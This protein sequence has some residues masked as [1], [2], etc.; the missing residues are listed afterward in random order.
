MSSIGFARPLTS[1]TSGG[2]LERKATFARA[3]AV[4]PTTVRRGS[5]C[6]GGPWS[7]SWRCPPAEVVRAYAA[8]NRPAKA[9]RARGLAGV[10]YSGEN[11]RHLRRPASRPRAPRQA[12]ARAPTAGSYDGRDF[13]LEDTAGIDVPAA[14]RDQAAGSGTARGTMTS[15]PKR[16]LRGSRSTGHSGE[17][18]KR[19][20]PTAKRASAAAAVD[21][22]EAGARAVKHAAVGG[23]M[24]ARWSGVELGWTRGNTDPPRDRPRS[25]TPW[26]YSQRPAGSLRRWCRQRVLV[27]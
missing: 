21:R 27:T 26:V 18:K 25:K 20:S 23:R 4:V 16:G 15:R 10:S 19:R 22:T 8:S 2:C 24:T 7:C 13:D 14:S 3:Q 12:L 1:C 11:V 6:S 9:D 17:P 5:R